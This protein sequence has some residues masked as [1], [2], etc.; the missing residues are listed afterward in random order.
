MHQLCECDTEA[1]SELMTVPTADACVVHSTDAAQFNSIA[2][3]L[4]SEYIPASILPQLAI[5]IQSAASAASVTGDIN[6]I[7]SSALT[8][9]TPA[10][11]FTDLP[12]Q[13]R[14]PVNQIESTLGSIRGALSSIS[15]ASVSS[16]NSVSSVSAKSVSSVSIASLNASVQTNSSAIVFTSTDSSGSPYAT[17]LPATISNGTKVAIIPSTS[18]TSSKVRLVFRPP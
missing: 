8:A 3:S 17:I 10:P 7:V 16:V 12:S 5:A 2:L 11:F 4:V 1:E 6:S 15:L 18:S 13:Y 9:A 14:G